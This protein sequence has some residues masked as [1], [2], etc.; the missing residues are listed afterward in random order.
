[1]AKK[2]IKIE[3]DKIKGSNNVFIQA[4]KSS[5]KAYVIIKNRISL[6]PKK[7]NSMVLFLFITISTYLAY[8]LGDADEVLE[9]M[10]KN[11]TQRNQHYPCEE[12]KDLNQF[13]K[14]LTNSGL[15]FEIEQTKNDGS[16]LSFVTV[17]EKTILF[18]NK[19]MESYRPIG[20]Y[21]ELN[22]NKYSG[23]NQKISQDREYGSK[24]AF[25]RKT[26]LYGKKGDLPLQNCAVLGDTVESVRNKC[27]D[28]FSKYTHINKLSNPEEVN[29]NISELEYN[30]NNGR[31]VRYYFDG[32]KLFWIRVIIK[33]KLLPI[34]R[35][36]ITR[37]SGFPKNEYS[38][39]PLEGDR[40]MIYSSGNHNIGF[41][42]WIIEQRNTQVGLS[43]IHVFNT[44]FDTLFMFFENGIW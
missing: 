15:E 5:I 35:E 43:E 38:F 39:K 26:I 42:V 36:D 8:Q 22:N 7:Y 10:S 44:D 40:I 2:K 31:A 29:V 20:Q 34:T 24:D 28:E 19:K 37:I 23:I 1:M 25:V 13:E 14:C 18:R 32:N 17:E 11:E 41:G 33:E 4:V 21:V 12:K 3:K 30:Y 16:L 9:Q 27:G 6:I